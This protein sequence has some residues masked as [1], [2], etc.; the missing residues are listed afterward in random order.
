MTRKDEQVGVS[1]LVAPKR[2]CSQSGALALGVVLI[3][4]CAG[5]VGCFGVRCAWAAPAAN[6]ESTR[7]LFEE[8][9]A[10]FANGQWSRAYA[11]FLSAHEIEPTYQ[12]LCR[13]GQVGLKLGR[14]A[15]AARHL[16]YALRSYP[17]TE[18]PERRA[19]IEALLAAAKHQS[20]VVT[21]VLKP[22]NADVLVDGA[23]QVRSAGD[24]VFLDPG[25]HI[26]TAELVGYEPVSQVV[27]A[28]A[29]GEL[30][31]SLTLPRSEDPEPDAAPSPRQPPDPSAYD[32]DPEPRPSTHLGW[33]LLIGGGVAVAASTVAVGFTLAADASQDDAA[34]LLG[35][36]GDEHV[37]WGPSRPE[38][39]CQEL[40]QTADRAD[41]QRNTSRVGFVVAGAAVVSTLAYVF[42]PSERQRVTALHHRPSLA[43][44]AG[45]GQVVVSGS[46]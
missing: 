20:S 22:V 29:G 13:L 9:D 33:A 6:P 14:S 45:A 12:S 3:A 35:E 1:G 2:H 15:E 27:T 21:L 23:A 38:L 40:R 44:G 16:W 34:K 25:D 31:L 30:N 41:R 17:R 10:A 32:R 18:P 4:L 5:E 37:C 39:A 11:L 19:E 36:L 26:V 8:G 28:V 7:S 46:F 42:W 43:L 24:P